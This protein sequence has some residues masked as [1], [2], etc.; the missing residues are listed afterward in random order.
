MSYLPSGYSL[1][2]LPTDVVVAEANLALEARKLSVFVARLTFKGLGLDD[3][4]GSL[5]L[6]LIVLAEIRVAEG[7]DENPA[8]VIPRSTLALYTSSNLKKVKY[9]KDVNFDK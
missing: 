1:D 7:A 8:S 2:A 9:D 6:E 5:V 4:T 3:L